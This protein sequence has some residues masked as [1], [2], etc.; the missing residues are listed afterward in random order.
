MENSLI[1]DICF[2]VFQLMCHVKESIPYFAS[3]RH[4]FGPFLQLLKSPAI[5]ECQGLDE[6]ILLSVK[7]VGCLELIPQ[8]VS[9]LLNHVYL[10]FLFYPADNWT[11]CTAAVEGIAAVLKRSP[12]MVRSRQFTIDVFDTCHIIANLPENCCSQA[13]VNMF[14]HFITSAHARLT[15]EIAVVIGQTIRDLLVPKRV[16]RSTLF[17]RVPALRLLGVAITDWEFVAAHVTGN[18][19]NLQFR[20]FERALLGQYESFK[21]KEKKEAAFV[22]GNVLYHMDADL[23]NHYFGAQDA[24]PVAKLFVSALRDALELEDVDYLLPVVKGLFRAFT[25][26]KLTVSQDT[27]AVEHIHCA[28]TKMLELSPSFRPDDQK[29]QRRLDNLTR[30]ADQLSR[31]IVSWLEVE[32]ESMD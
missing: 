12:P 18:G 17:T 11:I 6:L 26:P 5:W 21:F 25:M 13:V 23:I 28:L 1:K 22:I 29:K 4:F 14:Y 31:V 27:D 2:T 32:P 24:F 16:A 3:R 30:I 20:L 7:F 8:D 10:P 15:P 19:K 9:D